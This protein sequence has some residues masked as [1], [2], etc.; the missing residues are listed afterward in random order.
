[1]EDLIHPELHLNG[2][3]VADRRTAPR[4]S[5]EGAVFYAVFITG[6]FTV[7]S[8]A[9]FFIMRPA[10]KWIAKMTYPDDS[11]NPVPP[12]RRKLGWILVAAGGCMIGFAI[13]IGW[14]DT[15][16]GDAFVGLLY[17]GIGLVVGS[18][19]AFVGSS[20]AEHRQRR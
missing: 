17:L 20:S 4:M 13:G 12:N 9:T 2:V 10:V 11:D 19:E 7:I 18:A 8:R 14:A 15:L 5:I 6:M 16:K 3:V 1:M